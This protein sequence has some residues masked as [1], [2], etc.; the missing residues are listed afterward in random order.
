MLIN[1]LKNKLKKNL[2]KTVYRLIHV[3]ILLIAKF[4]RFNLITGYLKSAWRGR[5]INKNGESLPWYT[6]SAIGF[7][8]TRDFDGRRVLEF[9]AGQST[10]WWSKRAK[11]ILSI[12]GDKE[13]FDYLKNN[14]SKNVSIYHVDVE[15][16]IFIKKITEIINSDKINKYDVIVIDGLYREELI[17]WAQNYLTDS[18][19]I[20]C[21]NSEG[22]EI[23]NRT[24]DRLL[25]RVDFFGSAPGVLLEQNTSIFFGKNCFLF[26][27]KYKIQSTWNE[28]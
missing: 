14:M 6:Y 28:I 25:Q 2:P 10:I 16:N 3:L 12:E 17:D 23:Y 4:Y 13:W 8:S 1:N 21:D 19:L 22:Y 7:L 24:K 9:G 26:D 20:I 11:S 15:R 27:Q 5:A 18:G